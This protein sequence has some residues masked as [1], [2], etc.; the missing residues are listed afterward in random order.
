MKQECESKVSFNRM[1]CRICFTPKKLCI[2]S[3]ITVLLC[4]IGIFNDVSTK[5]IL[6][7]CPLIGLFSAVTF[8]ITN[9]IISYVYY[10]GTIIL[11]S[12]VSLY[13]TQ[14]V[15]DAAVF[16]LPYRQILCGMLIGIIVYLILYAITLNIHF[17]LG[18]GLFLLLLLST[19]NYYVYIFRG[20]ELIPSDFLGIGT[21]FNVIGQYTITIPRFVYNSWMLAIVY[22]FALMTFT[23]QKEQKFE[24]EQE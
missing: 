2:G 1:L 5:V 15:N 4:V 22:V 16:H 11:T 7:F 3:I 9:K 19:V 23:P 12:F 14:Q 20:N 18:I 24:S 21:A 17:S 8:H 10:F 13:L 6:I